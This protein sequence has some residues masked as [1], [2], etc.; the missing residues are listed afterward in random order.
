MMLLDD[1]SYA[2]LAAS[3]GAELDV[4][5]GPILPDGGWVQFGG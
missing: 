3:D 1:T 2:T 4:V 5:F